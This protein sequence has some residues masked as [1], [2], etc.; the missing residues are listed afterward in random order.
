MK[1]KSTRM[2]CAAIMCLA[3]L[4][5][6]LAQTAAKDCEDVYRAQGNAQKAATDRIVNAEQ[7]FKAT[8]AA[9]RACL[10]AFGA[11]AAR[12]TILLGA[13]DLAPIQNMV[14]QAACSVIQ[15][16][17]SS[18]VAAAG[19]AGGAAAGA[20]GAVAGA[21]VD[22]AVSAGRAGPPPVPSDLI[23]PTPPQYKIEGTYTSPAAQI[24]R[25]AA[26]REAGCVPAS[27]QQAPTAPRAPATGNGFWQS[28]SKSVLGG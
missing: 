28:L 7:E 17:A 13:A 27:T 20:A 23:C 26:E 18:A 14:A 12:M 19:A 10:E 24:R 15:K 5:P 6:G 25:R 22:E 4:R 9:A 1:F 21:V 3:V 2:A 16:G 11:A 8:V